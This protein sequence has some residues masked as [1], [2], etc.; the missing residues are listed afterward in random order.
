MV[1][2]NGSK[3]FTSTWQIPDTHVHRWCSQHHSRVCSE[4]QAPQGDYPEHYP[5]HRTRAPQLVNCCRQGSLMHSAAYARSQHTSAMA[6]KRGRSYQH[7]S[8]IKV[9]PLHHHRYRTPSSQVA[10]VMVAPS[11]PTTEYGRKARGASKDL[12]RKYGDAGMAAF[13]AAFQVT[14]VGVL[15]FVWE[16]VCSW[17]LIVASTF[18]VTCCGAAAALGLQLLWG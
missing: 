9:Y 3:V 12:L 4:Q 11:K 1:Y 7:P 16:A 14:F 10:R 8:R 6:N 18:Q 5:E 15:A 2:Y 17:D 13:R